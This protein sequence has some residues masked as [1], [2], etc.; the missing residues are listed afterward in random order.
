MQVKDMLVAGHAVVQVLYQEQTRGPLFKNF[1]GHNT[2]VFR[3]PITYSCL[4]CYHIN[5]VG[6]GHIIY[7]YIMYKSSTI[8]YA[9]TLFPTNF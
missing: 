7:I 2:Y 8:I 1:N 4:F 5:T 9:L 6:V 3:T